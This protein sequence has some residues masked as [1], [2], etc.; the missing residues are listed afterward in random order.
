MDVRSG[1]MTRAPL[2]PDCL[3]VIDMLSYFNTSLGHMIEMDKLTIVRLNDH[4]I[5]CCSPRSGKN[6]LA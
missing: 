1:R 5:S 6:D 2:L 3:S 4:R